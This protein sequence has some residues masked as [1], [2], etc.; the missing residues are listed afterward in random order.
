MSSFPRALTLAGALC[1]GISSIALAQQV[2]YTQPVAQPVVV[3]PAAQPVVVTPAQTVMVVPGQAVV[4][5]GAHPVVIQTAA[6]Q[7]APFAPAPVGTRIETTADKRVV[8]SVNGFDVV[9]DINGKVTASHALLTE[10]GDGNKYYPARNVESLWPLEVGKSTTFNI[11][12]DGGNRA[13]NLHVVRTE[14]ITVPAGTFYTYVIE[15]RDRS[16][17]GANGGLTMWYAPSVGAVV[18]Q[19]EIPGSGTRGRTPYEAT[20]IAMP[21]ALPGTLV[22]QPVAVA[23]PTAPVVAAPA[24]GST[25]TTVTTTTTPNVA[26]V[27]VLKRADTAQAQAQFCAEHGTTARMADGRI[28]T[29][30]C[31]SYINLDRAN[32]DA[33][34]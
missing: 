16:A 12:G 3:A 9:Y 8:R 24:P 26:T 5:T 23:V 17:G 20:A 22:V 34:R 31:A 33:W 30:D 32:Y 4:A 25:T 7:P 28:V 14:T 10:P 13:V 18:K 21:Y 19:Q 29:L 6:V 2:I 1:A 15:R 27:P 11:D